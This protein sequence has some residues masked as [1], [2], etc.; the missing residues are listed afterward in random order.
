MGNRM[1]REL[2]VTAA[3]IAAASPSL[4]TAQTP[5]PPPPGQF[6]P[7]APS[8]ATDA[9]AAVNP[10]PYGQPMQVGTLT[11]PVPFAQD[12]QRGTSEATSYDSNL[13]ESKQRDSGRGLTWFW[14][15][16]DGGFEQV[17]L[18]TFNVDEQKLTAGLVD[19]TQSGGIV[20]GGI[21]A[22]LFV[23]T[24]GGRG[25]MGLFKAWQLG[26]VGGEVGLHL[27][28]GIFEPHFDLGGGFAALGHFAEAVP[29]QISIRGGYA[30]LD[31]G[32]DLYAISKL[33]FGLASSF[34]FMALSRSAISP[35]DLATLQSQN[36]I[37]AAESA[38]L[39]ANGSAYGATFAVTGVVGLH[40]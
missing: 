2:S 21:G 13:E 12:P 26:R 30:R 23:F 15:E 20:G 37:T 14:L 11:A 40:I 19:T 31:A 29:K 7:A 24:I 27:P 8:P 16:A 9:A 5:P 36:V 1:W 17:G 38:I 18:H 32:L 6:Q 25:R 34:D 35:S 10:N 33:S 22:R 3:L 39:G 28:L 4:A